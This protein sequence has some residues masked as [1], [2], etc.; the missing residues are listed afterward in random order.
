MVLEVFFRDETLKL[1]KKSIIFVLL[2][3][4][5]TDPAN[6]RGCSTNTSVIYAWINSLTLSL[7]HPLQRYL[8]N[9]ATPKWLKMVLSVKNKLCY[10]LFG[11]SKS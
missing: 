10:N 3:D 1:E 5:L 6:A 7:T 2:V 9:A 11:D 8:Y 4:S